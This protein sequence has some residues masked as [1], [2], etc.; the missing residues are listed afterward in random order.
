VVSVGPPSQGQG[1]E[2]TL[3]QIAADILDVE[4]DLVRVIQGDT[5]AF[6]S[7][8]GTI[9]SRVI[10][11]VGN[12]VAEAAT[13]LREK[14]LLA[15]SDLLEIAP[16]DLEISGGKVVAKGAPDTAIPLTQLAARVTPGIG[17]MGSAGP[18]LEARGGFQPATVTFGSG[19]HAAVVE[20][21]PAS[22]V[23]TILRYVVVHDCGRMI[24]PAIVD[25]Q[26]LG[27]LAQGV[28]NGLFEELVY[29]EAGQLLTGTFADYPIPRATDLPMPIV[30]H[31]ETRS[32]R[33]PLGVKG[34]GEAGTVPGA[35]LMLGAVRDALG[36]A[37]RDLFEAP[38]TPARILRALHAATPAGAS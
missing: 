26:V 34:V 20:V 37:G 15:A 38:V 5:F 13:L 3:A 28:G 29:D 18:G 10:V 1:H 31:K 30:V 36:P 33:N 2:T 7:G 19:F 6:P 27:G 16:V 21:D 23:V 24:N 35:A 22:G 25:G 32:E 8:G 4:F 9:A 12:A 14:I 17:R 11:V